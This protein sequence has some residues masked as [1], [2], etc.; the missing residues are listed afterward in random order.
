[1]V[2]ALP[3]PGVA[4]DVPYT[5]TWD[6]AQKGA[7]YAD[8]LFDIA[9]QRKTY[10]S[11]LQAGQQ[12][13]GGD[14]TGAS[15]TQA[16]GGDMPGAEQTQQFGLQQHL[17]QLQ[18]LHQAVPVLQAALQ[19]GGADEALRAFDTMSPE[20]QQLQVSPQ[21]LQQMRQQLATNPQGT[22]DAA[23]AFV[24]KQP[25]LT[26]DEA[27]NIIVTDQ[28]GNLM[29]TIPGQ[30]KPIS[31]P[32]GTKG[33][34]TPPSSGAALPSAQP[35]SAPP[36]V[37]PNG[38]SGGD[39]LFGGQPAPANAVQ[40]V[41]SGGN[42]NAVSPVGAVGTMQTM[43]ATLQSP[44]YGVQP[45]ANNSP[46]E[47]TRVGQQYLQAMQQ[48]YGS[49]TLGLI[50]YN[51]G[52]GRTDEWLKNGGQFKDL[53]K[54]T[55]AYLG[56]VAVQAAVQQRQGS[57]APQQQIAQATGPTTSRLSNGGTFTDFSGGGS[58]AA[59][60]QP[61][62]P[63]SPEAQMWPGAS[64]IDQRTGHPIYPPPSAA[65]AAMA[66]N[67][68][69]FAVKQYFLTG[70]PPVGLGRSGV[71]AVKFWERANQLAQQSG[72][73]VS[74]IVG[75]QNARQANAAA[76]NSMVKMKAQVDQ[77][78]GTLDNNIKLL[79]KAIPK[80]AATSAPIINRWIQAGRQSIQGDPDVT[81]LNIL[82]GAVKNETAKLLS[83]AVGAQG[84]TDA[85]RRQSDDF[86]SN[87]SN[88]Q[89]FYAAIDTIRSETSGR[90]GALADTISNLNRQLRGLPPQPPSS[91]KANAA[92]PRAANPQGQVIRYDA[93][94]NRIQ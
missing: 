21:M 67:A 68:L 25:T 47:Q 70:K 5:N 87:A 82:V 51:M 45:A 43:P 10:Q 18:Y 48:H 63:G 9:K 26:K 3:M 57:Q 79:E 58:S 42:P 34:Y 33:F 56:Q 36:V 55:Q 19:H 29:H 84:I 40:S 91:P 23:N 94:G 60:V 24:L 53:P 11:Q 88:D 74:D 90:R 83:G 71:G 89:Q 75:A 59:P 1:M 76:L 8:M 66:D 61:I 35:A 37:M 31:V 62:K 72:Q 17:M 41:E 14:Y 15:Q 7:Q 22:I 13:A 93:Q 28:F 54:E 80:G 92:P 20:L 86:F 85:A 52:P 78:S 50:A 2:S 44:G 6:S 73:S 30:Q 12:F 49:P 32:Y 65:M 64:G 16:R 4:G 38:P 39:A 69:D 46:F 27:G 77:Y 81:R